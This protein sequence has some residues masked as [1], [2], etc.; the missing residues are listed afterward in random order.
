MGSKWPAAAHL[1]G[2]YGPIE[3]IGLR[4]GLRAVIGQPFVK[5]LF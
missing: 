2:W 5:P 4:Q 3:G 1:S